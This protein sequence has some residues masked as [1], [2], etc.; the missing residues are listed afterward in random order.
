MIDDAA[1]KVKDQQMVSKLKAKEVFV[2]KFGAESLKT[3]LDTKDSVKFEKTLKEFKYYQC[4][5]K[6]QKLNI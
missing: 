2:I 5:Y 4:D 6:V 1:S 3:V